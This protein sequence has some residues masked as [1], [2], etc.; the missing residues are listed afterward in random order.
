MAVTWYTN[1]K[2]A[3][4]VLS[5]GNLTASS[6]V[7]TAEEVRAFARDTGLHYME[8]TVTTVGGNAN[9]FLFGFKFETDTVNG[10]KT[11]GFFYRAD[12]TIWKDNAIIATYISYTDGDIIGA[13]VDLDAGCIWFHRNGTW[14]VGSPITRASPAVTYDPVGSMALEP[15]LLFDAVAGTKTGIADFFTPFTYTIP[16][17]YRPWEYLQPAGTARITRA[18]VEVMTTIPFDDTTRVSNFGVNVLAVLPVQPNFRIT[19]F[20][21]QVLVV[22]PDTK[23]DLLNKTS[24][25]TLL[26]ALKTLNA[27]SNLSATAR[28]TRFKEGGKWYW[29]TTETSAITTGFTYASGIVNSNFILGSPGSFPWASG[30]AFSGPGQNG[31]FYNNNQIIGTYGSTKTTGAVIRHLLDL[32]A[33]VYQVA[34]NGGSIVTVATNLINSQWYPLGWV[35]HVS[36]TDQITFNFGATPFIYSVPVGFTAFGQL[37]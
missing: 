1:R 31:S 15:C 20:G 16:P 35:S 6:T 19:N 36:T 26:N 4:I 30:F 32:D 24:N 13:A 7:S 2:T 27:T 22:V 3:N 8:V 14:I 25:A 11:T 29:E 28:A 37:I 17:L 21:A 34:I 33:D 5:N 10:L 9:S 23:L 12:G 18:G